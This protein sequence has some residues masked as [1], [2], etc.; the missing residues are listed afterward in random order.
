MSV[1]EVSAGGVV[2]TREGQHLKIMLIEDRY[3]RWSLPKGK[4]EEGETLVETAL[5]EILEETGIRGRVVNRLMTI[6]YQY[7]N[8]ALGQMD[9]EVH[10]FLVEKVSG[11]VHVQIEEI[12]SVHWLEPREAWRLQRNN[13]YENNDE[14]LRKA[15]QLL[16]INVG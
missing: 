6:Y 4:Q 14:V 13:G 1:K 9:K 10:Y 3:G 2:F 8:P 12:R 5:R 7:N 11:S 16:D 15:L